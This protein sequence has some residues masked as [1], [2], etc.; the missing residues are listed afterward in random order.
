MAEK[1][2]KEGYYLN[3]DTN[4]CRKIKEN[5]GANYSLEPENYE[6]QSSFVALYAVLGIV[7]LGM[8]Y[9]VYE[10]RHEIAKLWHKVLIRAH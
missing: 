6:E 4:R 10:F 3:P 2:C 9:L 1:T 8:I 7:G 5:K